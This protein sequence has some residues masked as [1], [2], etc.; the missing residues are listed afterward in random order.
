MV[1]LYDE[2]YSSLIAGE[3]I[4]QSVTKKS[5]RR[6]KSLVDK[7]AAA[8]ILEEYLKESH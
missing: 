5:K 6:D 4:I 8:V 2:R 1:E 3:R 7:F